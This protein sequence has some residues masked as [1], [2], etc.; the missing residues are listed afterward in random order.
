VATTANVALN[1]YTFIIGYKSLR[2]NSAGID[3]V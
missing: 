3:V 1:H 2:I